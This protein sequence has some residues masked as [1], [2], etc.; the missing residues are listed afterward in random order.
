MI[1]LFWLFLCSLS[2]SLVRSLSR[3]VRFLG[4]G[5]DTVVRLGTV[6][7][8]PR[9]EYHHFYRESAIF[10]YEMGY[11][12]AAE[13]EEYVVRG[14]LLDHPTPFTVGE[15]IPSAAASL[16][17]GHKVYRGGDQGQEDSVLLFHQQPKWG[18]EAIG[19]TGLYR[20]GWN[21]VPGEND[22]TEV[23]P[24]AAK[25]FFN[26]CEFTEAQIEAYFQEDPGND[27]RWMAF[28]V[29]PDLVLRDWGRGDCWR[30]L[31]NSMAPPL[32]R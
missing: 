31:R 3:P 9:N 8:A 12:L 6:L 2:G 18:N 11:L 28:E 13:P 27:D 10:L 23:P 19:A 16:L 5:P 7:V 4:T 14:V 32:N 30:Y 15:M 24:P 26:Y 25:V 17:A 21:H 1:F 20:G 29:A 22:T